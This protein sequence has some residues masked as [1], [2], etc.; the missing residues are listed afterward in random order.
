MVTI[1]MNL[2]KPTIKEYFPWLTGEEAGLRKWNDLLYGSKLWRSDSSGL[3]YQ[4][5]W[6][7]S[8]LYEESYYQEVV[9]M[10][11]SDWLQ[12]LGGSVPVAPKLL[13]FKA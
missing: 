9:H 13:H 7:Q 10:I 2:I 4:K 8:P 1:T 6:P 3:K 11:S 12:N 5:S